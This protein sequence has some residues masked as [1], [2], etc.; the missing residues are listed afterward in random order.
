MKKVIFLVLSFTM[1]VSVSLYASNAR[2]LSLNN[3]TLSHSAAVPASYLPNVVFPGD[4]FGVGISAVPD[5]LD[6]WKF[7]QALVDQDLYPSTTVLFDFLNPKNVSGGIVMGLGN[8]PLALGVFV[9][10]PDRNGWVTGAPRSDLE[11]LGSDYA[12]DVGNAIITNSTPPG[13]PDNI[14]DLLLALKLGMFSIGIG[15]GF[16]YDI[17]QWYSDE[18]EGTSDS[19]TNKNSYSWIATGRMGIG[20]DLSTYVPLSIDL[21]GL[22]LFSKYNATYES[23]AAA[24]PLANQD[25]SVTANNIYWSAGGRITWSMTP[26]LDLIILGEYARMPQDY[27]A[28]DDGS[29]LD[30]ATTQIDPASFYSMNGGLGLNWAPNNN[31]FINGLFIIAGGNGIFQ[32]EAPGPPDPFD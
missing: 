9:M 14:V 13:A 31:M 11:N 19:D 5:T 2:L 12:G 24:T 23:G 17:A 20:M 22:I 27:E 8:L 15:G 10:R 3:P 32:N 28:T 25:D 29:T 1:F 7:P 21:C 26:K 4:D 6:I 18:E 16:S 30:T